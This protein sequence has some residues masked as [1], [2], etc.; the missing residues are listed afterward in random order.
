MQD[1]RVL[2]GC[3]EGTCLRTDFKSFLF[4]REHDRPDPSV[5]DFFPAAAILSREGWLLL[6]R[7][8]GKHSAP[9]LIYPPCGGIHARDIRGDLVDLDAALIR[10]LKEETGLSISSKKLSTTYLIR[11][12]KRLVYLREAK[13][14]QH[15]DRLATKIRDYLA[16][17]MD[18]ELSDIVV[19]RSVSD[20]VPSKMPEFTLKYIDY[21]FS[22][23]SQ[24]RLG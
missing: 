21:L 24:R 6:G 12:S 8:G 7:T 1:W 4:W 5:T 18:P 19:V 11:D 22:K 9:N 15:G 14:E 2:D 13:F 23:G 20:S 10:E 17:L 16:R 3:L